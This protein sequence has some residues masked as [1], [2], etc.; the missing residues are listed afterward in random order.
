M[1]KVE[2]LNEKTPK[3]VSKKGKTAKQ[4]EKK[5]IK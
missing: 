5:V 4:I 2:K 3:K 1:K